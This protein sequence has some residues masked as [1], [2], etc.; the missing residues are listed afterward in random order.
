MPNSTGQM[1]AALAE[2]DANQQNP[3]TMLP[4]E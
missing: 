2:V 4:I 1:M 3:S